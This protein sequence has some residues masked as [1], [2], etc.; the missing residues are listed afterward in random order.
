MNVSFNRDHLTIKFN[1][2]EEAYDEDLLN[3]VRFERL[4]KNEDFQALLGEWVKT[5][6]LFIDAITKVGMT[7]ADSRV[8]GKKA[9]A[10]NGFREAMKLIDGYIKACN[11]YRKERIKQMDEDEK[12]NSQEDLGVPTYD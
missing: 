8:T 9:A 10:L 7:D 11:D 6:E 5:H 12:R 4:K 1:V 2:T 3:G